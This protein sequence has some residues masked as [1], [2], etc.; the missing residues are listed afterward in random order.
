MSWIPAVKP[1]PCSAKGPKTTWRG[2]PKTQYP[3]CTR[4]DGHGA[5]HR[6]YNARADVLAEWEDDDG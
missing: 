2:R 1:M 3:R 6:V 5:P 4:P